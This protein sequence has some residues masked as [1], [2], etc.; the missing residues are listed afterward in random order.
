MLSARIVLSHLHL[1]QQVRFGR[2][3]HAMM[4]LTLAAAMTLAAVSRGKLSGLQS[5][6]RWS[7]LMQIIDQSKQRT[8]VDEGKAAAP[9]RAAIQV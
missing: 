7:S 2:E 3:R 4:L 6:P 1:A 8:G 5:T 9:G